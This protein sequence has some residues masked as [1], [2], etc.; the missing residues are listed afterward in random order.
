MMQYFLMVNRQGVVRLAKWFQPFSQKERAKIVRE[1]CSVVITRQAKMCNFVE[2]KDIKLVYKR[3]ASLYLVVAID[4]DD[5]EMLMLDMLHMYV[6][7][8]DRYFGNVCELD[9]IF[10]FHRAYYLLDELFL[11]GE[12]QDPN[13][14]AALHA[15]YEGDALA[16]KVPEFAPK[17]YHRK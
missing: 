15:A 13:K 11:G 8:L 9:I 3:Y 17:S 5:N 7:T 1:I 16:E 4:Q 2:Y 10:N 14:R 12:L 6:E